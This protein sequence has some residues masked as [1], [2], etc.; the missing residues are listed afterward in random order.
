MNNP[1]FEKAL[2]N[3]RKHRNI[4]PATTKAEKTIQ[5]QN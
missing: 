1:V 3:V 2:D 5:C 4:K